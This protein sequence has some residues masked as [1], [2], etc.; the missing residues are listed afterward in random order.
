[1]NDI[2]SHKLASIFA[3][4]IL[5]RD[6]PGYQSLIYQ[7]QDLKSIRVAITQGG[8]FIANQSTAADS[9]T[10]SA[11][12]STAAP[13]PPA[14]LPAMA[15]SA[16]S[17]SATLWVERGPEVVPPRGIVNSAQLEKE[18]AR[19]YANAVMFNPDPY[20]G[21]GPLLP[22]NRATSQEADE[23]ED[24]IEGHYEVDDG[25]AFVR[26][27]REMFEEIETSV[28]R[29]RAAERVDHGT[30]A[31]LRGGGMEES[32]ADELAEDEGE[33]GRGRRSRG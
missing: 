14:T 17:K 12:E 23:D 5:E 29:W 20:R 4:P 30:Q 9:L 24:D 19:V 16:S 13:T 25:G 22:R 10:A 11:D 1:M 26:D 8:R 7:P 2:M 32:E 31:G 3:K 27:A 6:V 21:L 15:S 28:G 18:I 33:S